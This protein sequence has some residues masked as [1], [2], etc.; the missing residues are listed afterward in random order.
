MAEMRTPKLDGRDWLGRGGLMGDPWVAFPSHLAGIATRVQV[1]SLSALWL[2]FALQYF[3]WQLPLLA[4]LLV[5]DAG[6]C[7]MRACTA[8]DR[9]AMPA[10]LCVP[11]SWCGFRV[12]TSDSDLMATMSEKGS[13]VVMTNHGSRVDWLVGMLLGRVVRPGVRVG[14]VAEVTTM[15]MPV[16]GWSRG[17]FGDIFL[18]RTFHKDAARI[19]ANVEA[20]RTAGVDRM[21]FL[22]PEG[23]IVD[24]G[25]PGDLEYVRQCG[26]FMRA[27]GREPLGHLLTP[28]YKGVHLITQHA[29][30]A[31][32][33]VTMAFRCRGFDHAL[34][35]RDRVSVV[36]GVATGGINCSLRL[37]DPKRV[38][39]D[40]HTI[41]RGGLHVFCDIRRLESLKPGSNADVVRDTLLEDYE[42]KDK[43]LAHFEAT[44]LM[45]PGK[46]MKPLPIFHAQMNLTLAAHLAFSKMALQLACGTTA[47]SFATLVLTTWLVIFA[48]HS[49]THLYAEKISG[50]SR[51]SLLFETVLKAM[52]QKYMGKLDHGG[53][54]KD[55]KKTQ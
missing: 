39:P 38:V 45:A 49:V 9:L 23:A 7:Y 27:S 47:T 19:R 42:R 37:D 24:P 29:P 20:F 34:D 16:F 36:D 51:E 28:R 8:F 6:K 52:M 22:A 15:L 40:L 2:T 48:L 41:F 10:V 44:G 21:I 35:L 46:K 31:V 26:D 43:L 54:S 50:A 13:S 14:F 18:R 33:S 4:L 30:D 55:A 3:L 5:P 1:Y 12:H 11:Y 17:L 53:A 32:F 25:V